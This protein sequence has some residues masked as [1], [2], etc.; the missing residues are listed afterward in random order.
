[1]T[2]TELASIDR[3]DLREVWPNE[4]ADFTPWLAE[5][6]S[7]LGQALGIDLELQETEAAVGGYSLDLLAT[8]T[9]G[10]RKVVI[11]NQLES[12]N[13]DHLGK[14]L[15]YAAGLDANVVVWLTKEFRD[16]HRQAL[17]WLNQHTD[18]DTDFFGVTVE[19]WKIDGSRPAP[20]FSLIAAPNGW[21][22]EASKRS[23]SEPRVTSE[24]QEQYKDFFQ[25]LI[26]ILREE[27][28][29]TNAKKASPVNWYTF[30]TGY[31]RVGYGANFGGQR[32]ARVEVYIDY[33]DGEQNIRLL[34]D[35]SQHKD[36]IESELRLSLDWQRLENRRACRIV[37]TRDGSI[38]DDADALAETQ[39]W[40]VETLLDF[41]RV[42]DPLLARL[43]KEHARQ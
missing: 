15:T 22:K 2:S 30:T 10:S 36:Q 9:N 43:T 28:R 21:R 35:L 17:D 26:D 29:F 5:N 12:T 34:E 3:V 32:E 31:S 39:T 8:D 40:M 14:L 13:H 11:E 1:M 38:D 4:A 18:E 20:H 19:A 27:H 24:R 25:R 37:A 42:F 6:I 7:R 41:K 23:R 16:E 33:P